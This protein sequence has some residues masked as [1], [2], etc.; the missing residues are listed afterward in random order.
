[1]VFMLLQFAYQTSTSIVVLWLWWGAIP[2]NASKKRMVRKM[3]AD[4]AVHSFV[5]CS[6]VD[7]M[8]VDINLGRCMSSS[9]PALLLLG[10][11]RRGESS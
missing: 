7:Y 5:D 10:L 9:Q 11:F 6:L 4:K 3:S 8:V 1:M 2:V